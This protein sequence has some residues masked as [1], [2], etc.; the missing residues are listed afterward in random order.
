[1]SRKK[2]AQLDLTE[3]AEVESVEWWLAENERAPLDD[4]DTCHVR[5]DVLAELLRVYREQTRSAA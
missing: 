3:R 1:M 5:G 4:G 2:P